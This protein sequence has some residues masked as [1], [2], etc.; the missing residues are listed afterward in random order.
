MPDVLLLEQ[1]ER[2]ALITLN[3][4]DKLNAFNPE[5]HAE[6]MSAIERVQHDDSIWALV[7]T[8]AGRGFCSGADLGHTNNAASEQLSQNERLDEL[9]W[10]GRQALAVATLDKPAI[11]AVNGVAAGMGM[12]LSL[13]CD[14]RL[15]GELTR[16]RTAM[17]E[18]S[19]CPDSGMSWFLTRI[20]GYSRALDLVLTSRDVS[21]P[22]AYRLGL[23]D[24]FVGADNVVAAALQLA[25]Q[26]ASRPPT[27]VRTSKRVLQK[28]L[29]SDLPTALA[30]EAGSLPRARSAPND[31][32]EAALA[33]KEKRT[34]EYT[35]T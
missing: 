23:L 31:A 17:V 14:L 29:V 3:R 12:S 32:L 16:F 13:A 35:G 1:H 18:R 24:R 25:G 30:Y 8:G 26:I 34:P 28:A 19:R 11:A 5:L 10:F 4:P 7:I 6:F 15:G 22:E 27:A 9:K 33:F 20:L 2:V 21:G